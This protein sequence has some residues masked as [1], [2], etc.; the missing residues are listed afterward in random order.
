ML[1]VYKNDGD[2]FQTTS[3]VYNIPF[4]EAATKIIPLKERRSIAKTATG[5]FWLFA[6]GLMRNL[7]KAGI[8]KTKQSAEDNTKFKNGYPKLT[9]GR[10]PQSIAGNC[11]I[12]RCTWQAENAPRI[13]SPD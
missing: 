4:D 1:E 5:V 13:Y 2:I 11:G 10:K 6:N 8:E 7:K 3:V 12:R 9:E